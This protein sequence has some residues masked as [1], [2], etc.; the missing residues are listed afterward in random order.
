V[1]ERPADPG[2]GGDLDGSDLRRGTEFKK[3]LG[4]G[5]SQ[6]SK[7]RGGE[8]GSR[9]VWEW[10]RTFPSD[11]PARRKSPETA[12]KGTRATDVSGRG[13]KHI[14]GRKV[15]KKKITTT[16]G[17]WE[18]LGPFSVT[19][20]CWGFQGGEGGKENTSNQPLGDPATK[21]TED[22]EGKDFDPTMRLGKK[23]TDGQGNMKAKYKNI[24]TNSGVREPNLERLHW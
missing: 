2:L 6:K 21:T 19:S 18:F 16:Q 10:E 17:G 20:L 12:S 24:L 11:Q 23:G 4:R 7:F 15:N 14:G 22:G 13:K 9:A 5:E 3:E 8:V 1:G